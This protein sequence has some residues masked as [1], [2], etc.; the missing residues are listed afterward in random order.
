MSARPSHRFHT[1]TLVV[2]MIIAIL[3][4]WAMGWLS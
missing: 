2:C 4:A 1:A 3:I